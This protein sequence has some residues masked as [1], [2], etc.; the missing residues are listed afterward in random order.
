MADYESGE[1]FDF[2]KVNLSEDLSQ[3]CC[4]Y[5]FTYMSDGYKIK[6]YISIPNSSIESQE[7]TKCVLYNRGGNRDFGKLQDDTTAYICALCNRIVIASQYRGGGG[8]EGQDQFGGDDLNDV[9]KLIDL[10][11]NTFSFIDMDDFCVVGVSRGG[12][13]T[14]MAARQDNRIKKIIA[15]SAVTDLFEEYER[16]K[17]MN[18]VLIET[19]GCTPQENPAEYEKRSAIYWYDEIKIPVMI[20]H[21]ENDKQASYQA[22]KNF[23]LFNFGRKG[24]NK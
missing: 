10:C 2:E 9:I 5:K 22:A 23:C 4:S 17:D 21:S 11:E 18:D 15:A 7:L 14:Y 3:K 19:I 24:T 20:I 13:M 6:G 8:S 16:R 1:V 12:M